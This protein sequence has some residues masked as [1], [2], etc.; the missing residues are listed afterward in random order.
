VRIDILERKNE[1]LIWI[2][3]NKSK[4]FIAR[5]LNCKNETLTSYLKK[6]GIEYYGNKSGK[7]MADL[8]TR[9]S[10]LEYLKGTYIKSHLLKLKLIED[11]IKEHKCER[12]LIS[13]WFEQLIPLELHHKD[14]NHYNNEL[15]NLELL[16]PNCHAQCDNNSGKAVR[17]K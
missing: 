13:T 2:S 8:K 6:M 1:I 10:A 4:E 5:K 7:G 11:K 14:G 9:K 17:K 16:C 3:E 15:I 12:C